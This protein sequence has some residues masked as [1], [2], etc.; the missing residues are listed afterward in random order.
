[1][2]VMRDRLIPALGR[3]GFVLLSAAVLIVFSEKMFWYVT[4]YSFLD[5]LLGYFF[6]AF[7]LLWVID[8]FRVR[9]L[10]PLFLAGAVFGFLAEGMLVGTL[11]EG[12]PLNW[13]SVSYTPLAWHAPL[14]V[15]FGWY[16]LRHWLV[17]GQARALALG[18]AAVGLFWG[19]WAMAWWLPENAADPALLAQGAR[20]GQWPVADFALHAFTFTGVPAVA[21]WL[22]GRGG[23]SS[24][25]PSRVEVALVVAGLLVFFTAGVLPG[26]PWAPLK[27]LPLLGATLLALYVNKRREPPGSLLAVTAG[28]VRPVLLPL[29]LVMPAV[30]VGVYAV[31]AA[32]AP[33]VEVIYGITAIGGVMATAVLGGLVYLIAL[34]R[35]VGR[36]RGK[37]QPGCSEKSP[38]ANESA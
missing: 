32:L 3:V 11:Y 34:L 1:M 13:F 16:A 36:R 28:P 23:W 25:R 17:A 22:L 38:V 15:V 20:L 29:L 24:F 19:L 10:A 37:Q 8:A 14:S 30:A 18:C 31:A 6:P 9:R 26:A 27:L 2:S 33:P 4:G 7:I 12:G 35:T 5:L 21:L